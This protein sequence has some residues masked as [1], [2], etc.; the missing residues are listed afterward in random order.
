MFDRLGILERLHQSW[1]C[2]RKS[3]CARRAC[4]RAHSTGGERR[5]RDNSEQADV[6]EREVVDPDSADPARARILLER[7]MGSNLVK[8]EICHTLIAER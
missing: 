8:I 6:G 3:Q 5:G 7:L 4:A 1:K 2:D